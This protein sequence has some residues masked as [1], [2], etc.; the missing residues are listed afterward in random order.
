MKITTTIEIGADKNIEKIFQDQDFLGKH[1]K[2]SVELKADKQKI[3]LTI[4]SED[5]TSARAA[6]NAITKNLA[7]Y[8]NIKNVIKK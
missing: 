1:E 2:T 5:I 4:T 8:D 7:T 6:F 3:R